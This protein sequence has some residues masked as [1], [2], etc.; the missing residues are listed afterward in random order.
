MPGIR[1]TKKIDLI[2]R[3]KD[4]GAV[5]VI[6]EDGTW[7]AKE[8]NIRFLVEKLN[9]YVGY[10]KDG[11]FKEMYPA[12]AEKSVIIQV[13]S[14]HEFDPVTKQIFEQLANDMREKFSITLK[15]EL[16]KK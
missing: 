7:E 15:F 9:T 1:D 4:G 13:S 11:Q 16:M 3:A 2:T 6:T 8:E 14:F 10:I 12:M 5:L